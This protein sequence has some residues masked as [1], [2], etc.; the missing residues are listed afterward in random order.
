MR[1]RYYCDFCGKGTGSASFMIRHEPTCTNNPHRVCRM[2]R[3]D[4]FDGEPQKPLSELTP[5]ALA[6]DVAGLR[7]VTGGCP[8]CMLA[9]M[10]QAPWPV[11]VDSWED[12]YTHKLHEHS[13]KDVPEQI[14]AWKFKDEAVDFWDGVNQNN[15]G[16]Y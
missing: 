7:A 16:D 1:P 14:T 10:R 13:Y 11:K 4:G 2:H 15:R 3:T 5:F 12:Y 8:A 6:G 9:A